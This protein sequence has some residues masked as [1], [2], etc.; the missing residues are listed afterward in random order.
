MSR[1]LTHQME[2]ESPTAT[3]V[4]DFQRRTKLKSVNIFLGSFFCIRNKDLFCKQG[5]HAVLGQS[6]KW[7]T[8]QLSEE[9]AETMLR[10]KSGGNL[11]M[12]F[13]GIF[14]MYLMVL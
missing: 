3:F 13:F 4:T 1:V 9:Q 10:M 8:W 11:V 12:T 7:G 2:H 5:R 14:D 6:E